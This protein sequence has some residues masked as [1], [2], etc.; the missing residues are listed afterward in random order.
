[1]GTPVGGRRGP[2][3]L[4]GGVDLDQDSS[5]PRST[6]TARPQG[7]IGEPWFSP[8]PVGQDRA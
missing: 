1:M 5:I 8:A 2:L 6:I 7:G 3:T 4:P